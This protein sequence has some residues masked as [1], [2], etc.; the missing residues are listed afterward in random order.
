MGKI[1]DFFRRD[2][3]LPPDLISSRLRELGVE[4]EGIYFNKPP[5]NTRRK[6]ASSSR[7]P[8]P[9]L[10]S[11]SSSS[12]SASEYSFE[13]REPPRRRNASR[14]PSPPHARNRSPPRRAIPRQRRAASPPWP[15]RAAE[16]RD[17]SGAAAATPSPPPP[18]TTSDYLIAAALELE[19]DDFDDLVESSRAFQEPAPSPRHGSS[20][21]TPIS[22]RALPSR[23]PAAAPPSINVIPRKA[24]PSVA[25]KAGELPQ[26]RSFSSP[27]ERPR[28]R[29]QTESTPPVKFGPSPGQPRFAN[30]PSPPPV[31]PFPASNNPFRQSIPDS[32]YSSALSTPQKTGDYD[33][34]PPAAAPAHTQASLL[35]AAASTPSQAPPSS[36]T[37]YHHPQRPPKSVPNF[38]KPSISV[39]PHHTPYFSYPAALP[40]EPQAPQVHPAPPHSAPSVPPKIPYAP[41]ARVT[42]ATASP[43]PPTPPPHPP[44]PPPPLTA[45]TCVGHM[46][47]LPISHF[48]ASAISSACTHSMLDL[49]IECIG[50]S[51]T[52]QVSAKHWAAVSCPLCHVALSFEEVKR[53]APPET[54]SKYCVA[55]NREA[56]RQMEGFVS[57]PVEDCGGGQIHLDGAAQP[58]VICIKCAVAYC[59]THGK[60]HADLTCE[61]VD[62]PALAERR[63]AAEEARL[64]AEEDARIRDDQE[65]R[66]E[67]AQLRAQREAIE[68]ARKARRLE[69]ELGEIEA[70]KIS[71][72]CIG[73]ACK[74][75]AEKDEN[76]K[77][78]TCEWF[79]TLYRTSI[80]SAQ[81]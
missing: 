35:E 49:C 12:S 32:G 50:E 40:H 60:W 7:P 69:E 66:R 10:P 74:W 11:P 27:L 24:P 59:F 22:R 25:R 41:E 76:C 62:N 6:P 46:E 1:R 55:A 81:N 34:S 36:P 2:K 15:R 16:Q 45:S 80:A 33:L 75:R 31:S 5:K 4:D 8:R 20:P 77:H 39:V 58:M 54:F 30:P 44:S 63:R 19:A 21:A 52:S 53:W 72:R 51:L 48:P 3:P 64:R 67:V 38:S 73:P 65:A 42:I 47:E 18:D 17:G 56:L 23:Q 70:M 26:Y 79:G 14:P 78:V 68:A 37:A 28:P 29:L 9:R 13:P 71:K 57:C 61:E 43:R